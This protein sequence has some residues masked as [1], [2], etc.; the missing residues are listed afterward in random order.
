M[1]NTILGG[2]PE[3]KRP[4]GRSSCRWDGN[5]EM[6]LTKIRCVDWIQLSV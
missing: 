4:L 6:D 2:I 1:H 3:G 5:V